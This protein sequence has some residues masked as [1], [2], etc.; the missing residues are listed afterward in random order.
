MKM[1][2]WRRLFHANGNP[3]K[4]GEAILV[5]DKID[6]EIKTTTRDKEGNYIM[7]KG[8]IQEENIAIVKKYMHP[9]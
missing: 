6:S 9:I 4:A 3:K 8:A 1:M 5:S 7:I 2:E